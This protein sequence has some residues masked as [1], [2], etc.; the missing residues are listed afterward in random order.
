VLITVRF[1]SSFEPWYLYRRQEMVMDR[2]IIL[3]E[4]DIYLHGISDV[5]QGEQE[6]PHGCQSPKHCFEKQPYY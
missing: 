3:H 1:I 6:K 2:D 4:N 5:L